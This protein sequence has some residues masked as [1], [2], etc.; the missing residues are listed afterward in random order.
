[1]FLL[2]PVHAH[3]QYF[4]YSGILLIIPI[5]LSKKKSEE[6]NNAKNPSE[7]KRVVNNK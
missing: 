3:N 1:M 5:A 4:V 7:Y 6:R 2:L